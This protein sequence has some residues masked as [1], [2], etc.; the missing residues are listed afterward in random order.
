[1]KLGLLLNLLVWVFLKGRACLKNNN[2]RKSPFCDVSQS[3][4]AFADVP[5]WA[6]CPLH[7]ALPLSQI[8]YR[9]DHGRAQGWAGLVG[10]LGKSLLPSTLS[11]PCGSISAY[12]QGSTGANVIYTP[13]LQIQHL[14][15]LTTFPRPQS[16]SGRTGV[17]SMLCPSPDPQHVPFNHPQKRFFFRDGE[18]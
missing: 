6:L 18:V 15:R 10:K 8:C 4:S 9:S 14:E 2:H 17:R 11:L 1:M 16:L 13:V 12:L 5:A 3:F 7:R